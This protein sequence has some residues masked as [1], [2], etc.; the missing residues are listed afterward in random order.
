MNPYQKIA[1]FILRAVG[2]ATA[3]AG[4]TEPFLRATFF[5][6]MSEGGIAAKNLAD[7]AVAGSLAHLTIGV[8]LILVA[9][10][11]GK[12]LGYGLD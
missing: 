10:P 5:S 4:A 2:L 7:M 11:L 6:T 12:L 9:N 1:I 8:V 3:I